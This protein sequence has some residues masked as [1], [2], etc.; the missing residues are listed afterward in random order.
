MMMEIPGVSP[1]F[2]ASNRSLPGEPVMPIGLVT[3]TG[4]WGKRYEDNS[5]FG[6]SYESIRAGAFDGKARIDEQDIDGIES[7]VARVREAAKIGAKG[8]I[9]SYFP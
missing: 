7:S 1:W 4:E 8:V 6:E 9:I 2:R 3:N 5:W